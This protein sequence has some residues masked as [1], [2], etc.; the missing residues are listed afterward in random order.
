MYIA[1]Y[2]GCRECCC[3]AT[4]IIYIWVKF[5][6]LV[7]LCALYD[8]Y[9]RE[10]ECILMVFYRAVRFHR[11]SFSA[12]IYISVVKIT[13]ADIRN[14]KPPLERICIWKKPSRVSAS[15]SEL[16]LTHKPTVAFSSRTHHFIQRPQCVTRASARERKSIFV[17]ISRTWLT[18]GAARVRMRL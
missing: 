16:N 14:G 13:R 9:N 1:A 11:G 5:L 4:I 18:K 12:K 10:R 2:A 6:R 7:W 3:C 15:S 17:L 8:V